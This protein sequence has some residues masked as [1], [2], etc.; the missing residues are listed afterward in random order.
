[1][2]VAEEGKIPVKQLVTKMVSGISSND[3]TSLKKYLEGD[4]CTIRDDATSIA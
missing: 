4:E 2:T 3:L 1:M